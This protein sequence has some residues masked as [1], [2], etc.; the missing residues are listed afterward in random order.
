MEE[1][2][3][4]MFQSA[5]FVVSFLAGLLSFLSPC[6]L[7]L[8]PAY[9]S[10]I[11]GLSLS[12]LRGD[13]K[14]TSAQRWKIITASLMFVLGFSTVF[15]LLGA[16]M[17]RLIGGVF[18]NQWFSIIAGIVIILFGLHTMGVINIKFLNYQARADFGDAK[19]STGLLKKILTFFA[20]FLLGLSFALGW[21]PCIGPIFGS[22]IMLAGKEGGAMHGVFLMM[23]FAAGLGLPFLLTAILTSQAMNFLNRIKKHFKIIEIVA[24]V[25]LVLVGIA[26]A[27]GDMGT[28]SAYL[29]D[30]F[31]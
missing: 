16:S 11:S 30:L 22:I 18:D 6:V 1:S 13:E 10:Y 8:I 17:A 7:P 3:I 31:S 21:T 26:I 12:T 24:G 27:T 9:L 28:I 23:T 4:G 25:L 14:I 15:V 20:P 19:N 5:P 2:L 29:V